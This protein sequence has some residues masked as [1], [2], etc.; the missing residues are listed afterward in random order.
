[1]FVECLSVGYT[2]CSQEVG[3]DFT[4]HRLQYRA[5]EV[6]SFLNVSKVCNSLLLCGI[7]I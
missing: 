1:M 3:E 7:G 5:L 2:G 4:T 6:A